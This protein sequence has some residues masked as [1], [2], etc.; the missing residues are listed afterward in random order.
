MQD[1]PLANYPVVGSHEPAGV[2]VRLGEEA[3]KAGRITVGE[4]VAGYLPQD[5]CCG[6]LCSFRLS[7]KVFN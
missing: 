4:R 3:E 6:S 7:L 2:V 5:P 1:F